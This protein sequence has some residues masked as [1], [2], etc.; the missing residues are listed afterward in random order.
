[1]PFTTLL[2]AYIDPMSGTILLQLIVAGLIGSVIFFR[3]FVRRAIRFV[4]P[5]KDS[6]RD[7]SE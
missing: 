7:D 6:Q 3:N 2:W 1:M 4:L 5:A